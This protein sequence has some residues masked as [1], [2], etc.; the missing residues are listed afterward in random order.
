MN[1]FQKRSEATLSFQLHMLQVNLKVTIRSSWELG[2]VGRALLLPPA[3]LCP[4]ASKSFLEIACAL[5]GVPCVL[6]L[7][8]L[9]HLAD[10]RNREL[11]NAKGQQEFNEI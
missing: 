3:S 7:L 2:D 6:L 5:Q 8:A 4:L 1:N 11:Q 10:H 9:H